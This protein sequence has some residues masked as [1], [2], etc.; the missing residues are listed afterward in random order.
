MLQN[1]SNKTKQSAIIRAIPVLLTA[2]MFKADSA[3]F[4]TTLD[5]QQTNEQY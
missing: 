1:A 4:K 3:K 2:L 5:C